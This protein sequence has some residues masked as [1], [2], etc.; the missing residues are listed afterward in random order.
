MANEAMQVGS[1]TMSGMTTGAS[2]GSIFGPK[3]TAIGAGIGAAVGFV[4]GLFGGGTSS[5]GGSGKGIGKKTMEAIRLEHDYINDNLKKDVAAAIQA[6]KKAARLYN[7]LR[8]VKYEEELKNYDLA[9]EQRNTNYKQAKNL[10]TDSVKAF[11][12]TVDLN[13]ISASMAMNDARRVYNDRVQDLNNRAQL[14]QL[15][16]TVGKEAYKLNNSLLTET[17]A[18]T[19]ENAKYNAQG[20]NK[21]LRIAKREGKNAI[22]ASTRAFEFAS[23][24][25]ASEIR[26]KDIQLNVDNKMIKSEMATL[27]GEKEA[28]IASAKLKEQDVYNSLDNTIAEADFAQQTLQLAQDERYA[29]AAI[30]TDQLRRRGL[31]EQGAQIAKGQ[32]GRSAAK[33]V[34]GLAF[35]NQQAQALIASS[36]VRADAKHYIDRSK[37]A[38]T[39]VYARQQGKS[40]LQS[41]SIGLDKSATE[42]EA[43]ELRMGAKKS[44]L[45][46]RK[47]EAN[48][49]KDKLQYDKDKIENDN[50]QINKQLKDAKALAK[51]DL[52][53]LSSQV[54]SAQAQT[55]TQLAN[56]AVNQFNL[57]QQAKLSFDSMTY[58]GDSLKDELKLGKERIEF[59]KFL[60]NRTAA[61]QVLDQPKVPDLIAPPT[62]AP[63]LVQQPLP[64]IDWDKIEKMQN[65]AR[66]AKRVVNPGGTSD[67]TK[68]MSNIQSIGQQ[69][70]SIAQSFQGP[71]KVQTAQELVNNPNNINSPTFG[72]GRN[73]LPDFGSTDYFTD[74]AFNSE[75][76]FDA[77]LDFDFSTDF[78][79]YATP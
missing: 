61:S 40:E 69:A 34:Q 62:K 51:I 47:V 11:D 26:I 32:S 56:N 77:D 1:S 12:E 19:F 6:N 13:N 15:Q 33:S 66:K 38:Q 10:Y 37:I 14:L 22:K 18:A 39:L 71:P 25:A 54:L 43:A 76:I 75:A 28:I 35:A 17:M 42:F 63:D 72:Q 9:V 59:D 58:A 53:S 60:A 2:I 23:E 7:D 57:E 49:Q 8:D 30:Q 36:I 73:D 46:I 21:K 67:F 24:T 52:N 5:G 4:G 78:S 68:Y 45:N 41:T 64:D 74:P 3:G 70:A 65:Q 29:E 20:V 79:T 55:Q 16:V 31:L 27:K 48:M 44:E 50:K